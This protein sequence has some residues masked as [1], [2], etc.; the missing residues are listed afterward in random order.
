MGDE[1]DTCCHADAYRGAAADGALTLHAPQDAPIAPIGSAR[2]FCGSVRLR[3]AEACAEWVIVLDP[4][5]LRAFT[6]SAQARPFGSLASS[7]AP[8]SGG[9]G[10][11]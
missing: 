9:A 7:G 10:M 4:S 2:P 8:R 5:G 3:G 6:H 1:E 11:P